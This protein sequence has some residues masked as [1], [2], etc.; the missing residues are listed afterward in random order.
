M[1]TF[2][3]VLFLFIASDV[4]GQCY[5]IDTT[6]IPFSRST[7][8]YVGFNVNGIHP[9]F[10]STGYITSLAGL[11][12]NLGYW[13]DIKWKMSIASLSRHM[14]IFGCYNDTVGWYVS[15]NTGNK[16]SYVEFFTDNNGL[17]PLYNPTDTN[18][19]NYEL[20][21]DG[22]DTLKMFVDTILI[23]RVKMSS[24]WG[25]PGY[26]KTF[27][28][29]HRYALNK[30]PCD[31]ANVPSPW[32]KFFRGY[33]SDLKIQVQDPVVAGPVTYEWPFNEGAGEFAHEKNTY[34]I[35]ELGY[36]TD[37]IL[38]PS[39]GNHLHNGCSWN[40]DSY[41]ALWFADN[42]G[43][44]PVFQVLGSGVRTWLSTDNR[45]VWYTSYVAG[46]T[47][48]NNKLIA[49]GVFN[50]INAFSRFNDSGSDTLHD[51]AYWTDTSN[52][53]HVLDDGLYG[54]GGTNDAGDCVLKYKNKLIATG[55]FVTAGGR[56]DSCRNIAQ[57]DTVNYTWDSLGHGLYGTQFGRSSNSAYTA[58]VYKGN[59]YAGGNFLYAGNNISAPCLAKWNDTSWS[60]VHGSIS[61]GSDVFGMA[62]YNNRLFVGGAF[63]DVG[64]SPQVAATNIAVWND[65]CWSNAG[66]DIT[67]GPVVA[68]C[69]YNGKLYVGGYFNAIG[70]T[71]CGGLACYDSAS[72]T[73]SA[74]GNLDAFGHGILALC[75][76]NGKLYIT[77]SFFYINGVPCY[78]IACYDG[79]N[80]CAISNGL[81]QQGKSMT[82]YNGKLI[83]GG[84]FY[85]ADGIY[86][87]NVLSFS[88]G[89]DA[90][91][92]SL[93]NTKLPLNPSLGQ[94]YPNPFN[95]KTIIKYFI[96]ENSFVRI[97]VYDILGR[98]VRI[99][100]N[101]FKKAGSYD[102]NFD[103]TKYASG[104]YFYKMTVGNYNDVKKMVL[105]K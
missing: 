56:T 68:L 9:G 15:Y 67:G 81:E 32:D 96:P 19:H 42:A 52:Q 28:V 83:V 3:L 31:S 30:F 5:T 26:S 66:V 76:Y 18:W 47:V 23:R 72:N 12:L 7:S 55:S 74:V 82:V 90:S 21:F 4:F 38:L 103:A 89:S 95:P 97:V 63:S 92:Y 39:Y 34:K 35:S 85:S 78:D 61:S 10:M 59:L 75:S 100:V 22:I 93:R 16:A 94:N 79:S 88:S 80:V 104:V 98:E 86:C 36:P 84:N 2:I 57:M 37:T 91:T 87:S 62:V 11:Q 20:K 64:S 14:Y 17:I 105:V 49:T 13:F 25:I 44:A 71:S 40:T 69:V 24:G 73:W 102:V 99:L 6:N 41:D 43:S 54:P 8:G 29:G 58:C 46:V 101:E 51:I 45:A 53:W 1:K 33:I 48:W 65:S 77:G 60:D 50:R 27:C 70:G